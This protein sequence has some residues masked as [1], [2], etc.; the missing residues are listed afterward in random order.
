MDRTSLD[1]GLAGR[2]VIITGGAG[3]I[4]RI[5]VDHFLAAGSKVSSLDIAYPKFD[6]ADPDPA[7]SAFKAIHCDVSS[8]ES[9][10]HAFA[11]AIAA[12]GPVEIC[13]AL[14]S[15]DLSVLKPAPFADAELRQLKRVL[16]VNVTG[17]WL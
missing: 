11:Q 17:T 8:E 5:V 10:Q 9:V 1:L 2:S 15:F 13:I 7:S 14:A 16:D 4:G 3:L 12:H 6:P